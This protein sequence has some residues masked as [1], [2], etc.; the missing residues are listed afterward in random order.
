MNYNLLNSH[1]FKFAVDKDTGEKSQFFTEAELLLAT[2]NSVEFIMGHVY[3][4]NS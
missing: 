3:N 1:L 4:R 2:I